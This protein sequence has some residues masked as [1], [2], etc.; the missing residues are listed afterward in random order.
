[1]IETRARRRQS[2]AAHTTTGRIGRLALTA[3]LVVLSAHSQ[4]HV[5]P[6]GPSSRRTPIAITEIM[7]KPADRAD[8]RNL[9]FIEL[10]NSN[11]WPEDIG[12]YQIAGDVQYTF[13]ASTKIPAL[14]SVVVAAV[15]A[16]VQAV[17]SLTTNVFGPCSNSLKTSGTLRLH[18]EQGSVLLA[19]EYDSAAPWPMGADGTGHS[20]VLARAS[21]GEADA[22]AWDRSDTTGGS[23]GRADTNTPSLL[24]NVVLNEV[25][26]RTDPPLVDSI[27]LYNHGNSPVSLAGC[28]LSDRP[29]QDKFVIPAGVVI[30]ARVRLLHRSGARVRTE[31]SGRND[32]FQEPRRHA[33]P[34]RAAL[35][36]AGER[37]R[38]RAPPR[39]RELDPAAEPDA[40]F[41]QRRAARQRR[42]VQR[43]HVSPDIGRR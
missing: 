30:P 7:Y 25:L 3:W 38:P 36:S 5:E 10:Y 35:R 24:R 8:K 40:R 21:Y 15:P 37:R 13:P 17:Y 23:P 22:R 9:E 42:R 34:R 1:M 32:L 11:P 26:A 4:T 2:P 41:S 6:P 19:L 16:D 12:G 20:I 31:R 28:T 43:N 39:R 29:D 33:R 27:E 14:G 18:D